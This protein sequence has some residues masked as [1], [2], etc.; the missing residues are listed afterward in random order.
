MKTKSLL[1]NDTTQLILQLVERFTKSWNEKN[2][3]AFGECFTDN[4]EFTDVVG[5]TAIGK[6][7]I[8]EQHKFPF[9]VVMKNAIF[10]MDDLY[11]RSLTDKLIIISAK[12]KNEGSQT[13]KGDSLPTR[14]GVLQIICEHLHNEW[15]IRLVHNS[16]NSL[17]YERQERFIT[18]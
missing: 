3:D 4:A 17:P 15:K 14:N 11:I 18:T 9:E 13:P 6:E 8:K 2:I 1:D 10:E 5:Q 7:A 16:D 12:W